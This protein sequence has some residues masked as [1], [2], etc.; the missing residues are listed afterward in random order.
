MND[1]IMMTPHELIA[2]I[3]AVCGAIITIATATSIVI[4]FLTR[5]KEP[6]NLQNKRLDKIEERLDD[7]DRKLAIDKKRID[8]VESGHEVTQEALLALLNYSLNNDEVEGLRLAKKK[9][10]GYLISKNQKE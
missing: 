1:P 9:L 7:M 6:E 10:E 4:K 2:I 5:L 3:V 8:N